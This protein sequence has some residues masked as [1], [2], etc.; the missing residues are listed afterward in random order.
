MGDNVSSPRNLPF[1]SIKV[2]LKERQHVR[3][4]E[5]DLNFDGLQMVPFIVRQAV[6]PVTLRVP[7]MHIRYISLLKKQIFEAVCES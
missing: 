6:D 7:Q 2:L 5:P 4:W 1:K 3:T